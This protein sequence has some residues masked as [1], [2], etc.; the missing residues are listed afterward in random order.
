MNWSRTKSIFI[1]AFLVL[2]VFLGYQLWEKRT[3]NYEVANITENSVEDLL[4]IWDI[5]I[6]VELS[7]D[8]PEMSQLSAQFLMNVDQLEINGQLDLR[9]DEH[10][11]IVRLSPPV[12]WSEGQD[13]QPLY[14]EKLQHLVLYGE[15]YQFDRVTDTNLIFLQQ[16]NNYPV[17][18]GRLQFDRSAEKIEGYKQVYYHV[19][20]SGT[21]QPVISSFSSLRSLID[22]QLIEPGSTVRDVQLGYYGQVY[23]VEI[24][25]LTPVWRVI[26]DEQEQTKVF[27]VNAITGA[28]VT[29]HIR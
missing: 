2:N 22:N 21:P 18:V 6:D 4:T 8:Q 23:E 15:Q 20:N 16:V 27:Y 10:Q 14:E 29:E 26:V 12:L 9:V 25:V 28:I 19:V 1:V 5:E 11:I 3:G 13:I 7:N 17:F 24:Q